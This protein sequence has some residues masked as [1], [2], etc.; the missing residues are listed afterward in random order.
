MNTEQPSLSEENYRENVGM[1]LKNNHGLVLAGEVFRYKGEWMMPQGGI[2]QAESPL[3]AMERELLEE[4][5]I[6]LSEIKLLDET[7]SWFYYLLR[8]PLTLDGKQYLGQK[9]KWFLME[10]QGELP[11]AESTMDREFSYFAWVEPEWLVQQAAKYKI[12]IYKR[13]FDSFANHF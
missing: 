2:K 1:V 13:V 12:D 10:Y 4:T 11:D 9:Q 6:S 7:D 3:Q 5:G 8:R